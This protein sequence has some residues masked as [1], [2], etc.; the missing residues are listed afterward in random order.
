MGL[1]FSLPGDFF[2]VW[3]FYG[4]FFLYGVVF[5]AIAHVFYS[6]ALGFSPLRPILGVIIISLIGVVY[7]CYLP[8][9][10]GLYVPIIAI[11]ICIIGVVVWRAIARLLSLDEGKCKWSQMIASFGALI[12]GLS[13]FV[14]GTNKWILHLP[15]ARVLIMVTYWIGQMLL[16]FSTVNLGIYKLQEKQN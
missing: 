15:Y 7:Y 11:Y 6:L 8:N 16:A 2:L 5:F 14:L 12:F 1:L 13:D 10:E 9:L 3:E 4:N